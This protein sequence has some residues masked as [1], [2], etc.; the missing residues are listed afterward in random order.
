MSLAKGRAHGLPLSPAARCRAK[1]LRLF[2]GGFRDPTYVAWERE[3]KLESHA[4]WNDAL[5]RAQMERL[6]REGAWSEVAARALRVEQR[7]RHPMLFSFEKMA[8]R[9]AV[10]TPEGARRF[11][12][13]L[14]DFLHGAGVPATRFARWVDALDALPRKGTRVLTWPTATVF[15]FLAQPSR[16]LFVKPKTMRRAAREYGADLAY[17]ARPNPDTYAELLALARR[18]LDEHKDLRPRDMIDAQS[19]LWVV[20]SDEYENA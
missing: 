9:D 15:G 11:A 13:G 19:F 12:E 3:Y 7:S 20:G 4:G 18:V 6:L 10:K 8:L 5:G 16:H 1:F 14:H 17:R 2:P